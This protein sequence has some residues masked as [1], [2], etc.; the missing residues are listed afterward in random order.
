MALSPKAGDYY[1]S[2][3]GKDTWS[4]MLPDPNA[5]GTD[6][7]LAKITY[8]RDLVRDRTRRGLHEDPITV[9][10]RDG[11]YYI[12][13][14]LRFDARDGGP[15]TF[16]AYPGEKP[17][18]DA[19]VKISGWHEEKLGILTV[20]TADMRE[21]L[22]QNGPFK[23]LY[24]NGQRRFRP[25]FPK[26][27]YYLMDE[28]PEEYMIRSDK[29]FNAFHGCFAFKFKKDEV[30]STWKNINDIQAVGLH[31][32]I[33]ERMPVEWIDEE[34]RIL[35]S[36]KRSIHKLAKGMRYYIDNVFEALTEPGLWY[37]D[38]ADGKLYYA[39]MP[40]ETIANTTATA[41]K[42]LQFLR[43][44]GDLD[45][46]Q[47]VKNLHFKGLTF[48]HTDWQQPLGWG[49]RFD[50]EIP[51]DKQRP[52]DSYKHFLRFTLPDVDY[53]AP[54]QAGF[55]IP[56]SIVLEAAHNCSIENCRIAHTGWYGIELVEGC[57][58][59]SLIGN[60]LEDLGAGG[61]KLDGSDSEGLLHHRTGNNWITD[62]HLHHL[63]NVFHSG[64]GMN[65]IHTF[66]NNV[67][68]NHIHDLY[69][70]GISCGWIWG[71]AENV[72]RDNRI[73]FNHI[74]SLGKKVL[75]D[76]GGIYMLGVQPGTTLRNNLIHDVD[77]SEYGGWAIYTDEGS[78]HMV[79]EN[80]IC[81]NVNS[82]PY[83]QHYGRENLIRNNV[84]AFGKQGQIAHGRGNAFR[85]YV[86][87]CYNDGAITSAFTFI[88]NIVIT[89]GLP[90]FVCGGVDDTGN[91][92]K[93]NFHSDLNLFWDVSGTE[94]VSIDRLHEKP[95]SSTYN[96][97][98][99]R[100]VG[101]DLHSVVADPKCGDLA[102][103]DFSLKK[104][105]PAFALGFR[106]ID[107]STVGVRPVE[108]RVR[109]L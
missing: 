92:S 41:G 65:L 58:G 106:P 107:M 48:E 96:I 78:S 13:E 12:D 45:N 2:P 60:E 25:R 71:Y 19:G 36:T 9:W 24:V 97:A 100:E 109:V 80:N 55:N 30:K 50:P 31:I 29:M 73:E 61:I 5:Q 15:T 6:G 46:K 69:Y 79:I 16:A 4:G 39:P 77:K 89:N 53:A 22:A 57:M 26:E 54:I 51:M 35:K 66:G 14:P 40:G 94:I 8:A 93:K 105:S 81:Y 75:S 56:G 68:H 85:F 38:R 52:Q 70:S 42:H 18:I 72:S 95:I 91:F 47:F 62:N 37:L 17:V 20:W 49:R 98:K 59:N 33:E 108:K 23:S 64:C 63:G 44:K 10:L 27:G 87:Q 102:K 32:W 90:I 7:P 76:M 67:L 86:N 104:D 3:K 83:F 74:H 99:M 88:N 82:Q 84:F 21:M 1:V 11:R 101:Y 43:V 28:I 34:K 103:F